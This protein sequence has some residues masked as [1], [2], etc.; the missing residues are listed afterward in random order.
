MH[1]EKCVRVD[2][3]VDSDN[4]QFWVYRWKALQKNFEQNKRNVTAKQKFSD[5]LS[6]MAWNFS[7]IV[8]KIRTMS[9]EC[10]KK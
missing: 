1:M 10:L 8:L 4:S 6:K 3:K 9:E 5:T 2:V 7:D